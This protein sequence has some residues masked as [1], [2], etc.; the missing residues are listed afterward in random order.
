[1]KISEMLTHPNVTLSVTPAD[2]KEFALDVI[3]EFIQAT[4]SKQED[5]LSCTEAGAYLGVTTKTFSNWNKLGLIKP[6]GKIGARAY[7][8]KSSLDKIKE[9]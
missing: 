5:K 1:M 7:Y 2:L 6:D 3:A 4:A 8:L 9:L